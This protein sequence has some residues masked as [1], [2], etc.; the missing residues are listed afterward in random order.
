MNLRSGAA[1]ARQ[2][3]RNWEGW[4]T[5]VVLNICDSASGHFDALKRWEV[6]W[7]LLTTDIFPFYPEMGTQCPP[8]SSSKRKRKK[9]GPGNGPGAKRTCHNGVCLKQGPGLR[10]GRQIPCPGRRKSKAAS[11][12]LVACLALSSSPS[13]QVV[14]IDRR[15]QRPQRQTAAPDCVIIPRVFLK[16]TFGIN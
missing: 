6:D 1:L 14:R 3:V 9:I 11:L 12:F 10:G 8:S 4:V 5:S 13:P 7:G 16:F 15:R 2:G